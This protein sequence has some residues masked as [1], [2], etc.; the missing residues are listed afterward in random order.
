MAWC[1]SGGDCSG[2]C[3]RGEV[4]CARVLPDGLAV[5]GAGRWCGRRRAGGPR[6]GRGCQRWGSSA[7]LIPT[8]RAAANPQACAPRRRRSRS[9]ACP[10]RCSTSATAAAR[11][12]GVGDGGGDVDGEPADPG[13]GGLLAGGL[14]RAGPVVAVALGL[15]PAGAGGPGRADLPGGDLRPRRSAPPDRPGRAHT[16]RSPAAGTGRAR[17]AGPAP[18]R[19]RPAAAPP[20]APRTPRPPSRAGRS[21][22]PPRRR[23]ARRPPRP[24]A[25]P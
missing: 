6:R 9:L 25:A 14:H 3:R 4:G 23:P 7:G 19:P 18:G 10:A 13:A 11:S 21:P 8:P 1:R 5:G 16:A 24:A 17:A 15:V 12:V 2:R 22:S 20:A